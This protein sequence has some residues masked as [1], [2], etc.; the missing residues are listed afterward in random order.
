MRT[1]Y[2]Y[3]D[4]FSHHPDLDI[5]SYVPITCRTYSST[6]E[7]INYLLATH[8]PF[9][10]DINIENELG[11]QITSFLSSTSLGYNKIVFHS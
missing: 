3:A 8:Q 2:V 9:I 11:S 7:V 1:W 6:I 5:N 10:L 4:H